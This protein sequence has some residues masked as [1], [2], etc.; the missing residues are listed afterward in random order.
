MSDVSKEI[1][2]VSDKI[3]QREKSMQNNGP[4]KEVVNKQPAKEAA[5]KQKQ[6]G[7]LKM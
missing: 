2:N 3:Q 4:K 7:G 6:A 1:R 5:N